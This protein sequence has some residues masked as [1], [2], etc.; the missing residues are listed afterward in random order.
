VADLLALSLR[1]AGFTHWQSLTAQAVCRRRGI[2]VGSALGVIG[3]GCVREPRCCPGAEA[4]DI[5][6]A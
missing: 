3:C 5:S 2:L 6:N 1:K 4:G